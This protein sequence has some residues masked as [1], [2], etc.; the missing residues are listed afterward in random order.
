MAEQEPTLAQRVQRLAFQ[1]LIK[2]LLQLNPP[3]TN[4][5]E[6]LNQIGKSFRLTLSGNPR[7]FTKVELLVAELFPN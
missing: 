3:T 2:V 5:V 4:R 6:L 7:L 1:M